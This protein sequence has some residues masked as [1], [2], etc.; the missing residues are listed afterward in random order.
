LLPLVMGQE[1]HEAESEKQKQSLLPKSQ[2]DDIMANLV[3]RFQQNPN[4]GGDDA[5]H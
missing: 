2:R 1:A 4:V 3:S 5:A